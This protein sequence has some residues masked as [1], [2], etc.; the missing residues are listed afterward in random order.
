M[1]DNSKDSTF[2]Q[3]VKLLIETNIETIRKSIPQYKHSSN[4]DLEIVIFTCA[5]LIK[6]HE[7]KNNHVELRDKLKDII[8]WF[9]TEQVLLLPV[10]YFEKR[11][12][13]YKSDL[14]HCSPENLVLPLYSYYS[15]VKSPLRQFEIEK[16]T[17]F[18]T[19]DL[20][21]FKLL[22]FHLEDMNSKAAA[23]LFN[24]LR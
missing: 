13:E 12:T 6:I 21:K 1:Q 2:F 23:F 9:F 17:D 3:C 5:Q 11:L 18:D 4:S 7:S 14:E 20:Y 15:I 8:S 22:I 16:V 19:V 10:D 24:L